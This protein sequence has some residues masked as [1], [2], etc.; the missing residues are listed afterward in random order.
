MATETT[1][2]ARP[3]KAVW[4]R[5]VSWTTTTVVL[6]LLA[7]AVVL[8]VIPALHGGKALTVLTGSMSPTIN[9]GDVAVVYPVDGFDDIEVGDI[10]TF[11]PEPDNPT[12]VT[13]RAVSWGATAKG[14]R[15]LITRGDA[16]GVDDDPIMEKQIRA[17][18]AYTVPWVGHVLQ[19]G[20]DFGKPLALVIVAI[21]LIGYCVYAMVTSVAS[22][23][24]R[25]GGARHSAQVAAR[26]AK[27]VPW[28]PV[29]AAEGAPAAGAGG[30]GQAPPMPRGHV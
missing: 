20:N 8:A 29:S 16:N 30:I 12:L 6:A 5:A 10:V 26:A 18:V 28:A 19:Y 17:K 14:E 11:M 9:A 22:G 2:A 13:H 4:R 1:T 24:E 7:L 27:P 21:G 23:R 3:R 15:L 25:P